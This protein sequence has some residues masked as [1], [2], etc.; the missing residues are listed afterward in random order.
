[1]MKILTKMNN[2]VRFIHRSMVL[3]ISSSSV[4]M[5]GT[6]LMMKYPIESARLF[7]FI[8]EGTARYVHNQLA[9][10]FGISLFVMAATGIFMYVYP[11]VLKNVYKL[12]T[13]KS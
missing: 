5:A 13:K 3:V 8:R 7:P 6:G 4:I 10:I 2:W 12:S 11:L 9:V 1:M